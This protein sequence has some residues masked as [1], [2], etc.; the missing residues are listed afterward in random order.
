MPETLH[1]LIAARLDGLPQEERRLLQDG[2]VLGKSFTRAALAALTGLGEAELDL[3][4]HSLVR[5][6]VSRFNPI[7]ARPSTA[8]TASCKTSSAMSPTRH[9]PRR[10]RRA[11]HL[12]AAEHLSSSPDRG[13]VDRGHRVPPRRGIQTRS[14]RGRRVRDQEPGEASARRRRGTSGIAWRRCGSEALLR[15][16]CGPGAGK[17][18]CRT[19]ELLA[20]AGEMAG[21]RRR[22]RRQ[23]LS[24]SIEDRLRCTNEAE[25]HS[26]RGPATYQLVRAVAFPPVRRDERS[27][28]RAAGAC[29]R[30]HLPRRA[31][32]GPREAPHAGSARPTS[33]PAIRSGRWRGS[34]R[35]STS[36]RRC[37]CRRCSPAAGRSR[38]RSSRRS[39]PRK[40]AS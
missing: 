20:R 3:L 19:P 27:P 40:H 24:G 31:R 9:S 21:T 14:R 28:T 12:A 13:R 15:A 22:C 18:R 35:A 33:S 30:G 39:V 38:A 32:R 11:R 7:R 8:S 16:G 4:L 5:K 17:S 23:P 6:E 1:A 26:R 2:S 36:P 37:S 10:E 29:V 34:S 25:G